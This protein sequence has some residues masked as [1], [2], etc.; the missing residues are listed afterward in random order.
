MSKSPLNAAMNDSAAFQRALEGTARDQEKVRDMSEILTLDM[1]INSFKSYAS[2]GDGMDELE[3][4][5]WL[6]DNYV[7]VG[8]RHQSDG[9]APMSNTSKYICIYCGEVYL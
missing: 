8:H 3:F 5:E 7:K 4:K 6:L 2:F 9:V 1:A